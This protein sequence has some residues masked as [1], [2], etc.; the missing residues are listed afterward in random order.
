MTDNNAWQLSVVS[1]PIVDVIQGVLSNTGTV[2]LFMHRQPWIDEL[3]RLTTEQIF[4]LLDKRTVHTHQLVKTITSLI[5]SD[6]FERTRAQVSQASDAAYYVPRYLDDP[7]D[8]SQL[9]EID[10]MFKA[11]KTTADVDATFASRVGDAPLYRLTENLN[12]A[13]FTC[14]PRFPSRGDAWSKAWTALARLYLNGLILAE[15]GSTFRISNAFVADFGTP[16]VEES[17]RA[18]LFQRIFASYA[19]EDLA[20]VEAVDSVVNAL[21]VGELRWDLKIFRS[22]DEWESRIRDE[23]SSADTFQLFW[24]Q[25]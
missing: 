12:V 14:I 24:S 15:V 4:G 2:V 5:S 20:V 6:A 21:G 11:C 3:R 23:I 13:M 19:R 25:F 8:A 7:S 16:I 10:T 22:G 9:A 17:G 1:A 18:N